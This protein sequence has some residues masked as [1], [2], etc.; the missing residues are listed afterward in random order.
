M[1]RHHCRNPDYIY[2]TAAVWLALW[3]ALGATA[4]VA[5][6]TPT[7]NGPCCCM[8]GE[9]I[10]LRS[11]QRHCCSDSTAG[12]CH[13]T[14]SDAAA[15][16][17]ATVFHALPDGGRILQTLSGFQRDEDAD[18]QGEVTDIMDFLHRTKPSLPLYL[19]HNS[20]LC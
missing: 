10:Q 18:P 9:S 4:V 20:L 17:P 7:C 1:I 15:V 13:F 12:S 5:A 8:P 6:P 3:L 2:K 16:Q 19:Q 14:A 11:A